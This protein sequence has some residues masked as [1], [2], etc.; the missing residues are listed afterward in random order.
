MIF[1]PS[2]TLSFLLP[3][4][5]VFGAVILIFLL[6]LFPYHKFLSRYTKQRLLTLQSTMIILALEGKVS[7]KSQAYLSLRRI[8]IG[9]SHLPD[10]LSM[11]RLLLCEKVD[12]RETKTIIDYRDDFKKDLDNVSRFEKRE[13]MRIHESIRWII[14]RHLIMGS[15]LGPALLIIPFLS[16]PDYW[17]KAVR[18]RINRLT[19]T[20][21]PFEH[22]AET[23][24]TQKK[25]DLVYGVEIN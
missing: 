1:D 11:I 7:E 5:I 8:I 24:V 17:P 25:W 16:N 22:R 20:I 9:W 13:L 2:S 21:I 23:V 18:N 15:P 6:Y 3:F 14:A 4:Y 10:S 12:I 19:D